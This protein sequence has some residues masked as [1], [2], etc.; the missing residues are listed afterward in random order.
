MTAKLLAHARA[1]MR[2]AFNFIRA[3]NPQSADK[4]ITA[5]QKSI[6]LIETKPF[7]GRF[8]PEDNTREWSIPRWPYV[9]VY[10][11]S[12]ENI[13]VLRVWHTRR[14]RFSDN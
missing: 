7:I 8:D 9:I 12:G 2:Q 1:D 3:E 10:R 4:L 6:S 5:I 14:D 13:D 11:V